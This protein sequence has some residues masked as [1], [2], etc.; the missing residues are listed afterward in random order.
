LANDNDNNKKQKWEQIRKEV[1]EITSAIVVQGALVKDKLKILLDALKN[2]AIKKIFDIENNSPS[3]LS[4]IFA[5]FTSKTKKNFEDY[6]KASE[7]ITF[8]SVGATQ[9]VTKEKAPESKVAETSNNKEVNKAAES[10]ET[11]EKDKW[12]KIREELA[13]LSSDVI[14]KGALLKDKWKVLLDALKNDAIKKIFDIENNSPSLLSR[15]FGIFSSKTKTFEDLVKLPVISFNTGSAGAKQSNKL[16]NAFGVLTS[17]AGLFGY[18]YGGLVTKYPQLMHEGGMVKPDI[19]EDEVIRKLKVGE[20]VL[21]VDSNKAF[22]TF[23]RSGT[24]VVPYLKNPALA[25]S[26]SMS[27]Q[28]QQSEKHIQELQRQNELMVQ[29]NQMIF[30]LVTDGSNGQ[31]TVAQPIVMQQQMSMDELAA[32][33]NKMKRYGYR[34]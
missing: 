15:I 4:R 1:A 6:V 26:S 13:A 25:K 22:E 10:K 20:R 30:Q 2:D 11:K 16:S 23:M 12:Y 32:M 8:S 18:H 21:T 14:V 33:L 31:T 29:Q 24:D 19:K 34:Y 7:K 27:L 3:L 17:I 9:I 28:V 5:I